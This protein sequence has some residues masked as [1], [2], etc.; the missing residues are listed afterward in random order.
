M[1]TLHFGDG[2]DSVPKE[3]GK[4]TVTQDLWKLMVHKEIITDV[5]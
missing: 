5:N 1:K 4:L 2:T 3:Y